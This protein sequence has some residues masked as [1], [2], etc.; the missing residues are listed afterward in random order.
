MVDPAD[1]AGDFGQGAEER[2]ARGEEGVSYEQ[3]SDVGEEEGDAEW[4][5]LNGGE[6]I[7]GLRGVRYM[8]ENGKLGC[9]IPVRSIRTSSSGVTSAY[10]RAQP[11][12]AP[13]IAVARGSRGGGIAEYASELGAAVAAVAS[14]STARRGLSGGGGARHVC[15]RRELP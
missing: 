13:S 12:V 1:D 3:I 5:R 7:F 10:E 6:S 2:E 14:S 15:T 4:R 8:D 11:P 9:L